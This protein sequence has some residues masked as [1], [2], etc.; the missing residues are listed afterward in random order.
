MLDLEH[1]KSVKKKL[2]TLVKCW[3]YEDIGKILED[4]GKKFLERMPV[5]PGNNLKNSQ[6]GLHDI[7]EHLYNG[8]NNR[9]GE[10]AAYRMEWGW[11]SASYSSGEK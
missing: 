9:R 10:E 1:I 8:R 7:E 11:E 3:N 5:A 4:I 6:I 2:K